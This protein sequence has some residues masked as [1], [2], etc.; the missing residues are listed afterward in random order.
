MIINE[1]ASYAGLNIHKPKHTTCA[2]TNTATLSEKRIFPLHQGQCSHPDGV[3]KGE[4]A[5]SSGGP[6]G[7]LVCLHRL[8]GAPSSFSDRAS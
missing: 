7:R 6:E 4:A 8:L 2:E 1:C 3:A 5:K